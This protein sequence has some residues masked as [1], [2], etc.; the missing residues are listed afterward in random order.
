MEAK[1]LGQRRKGLSL[2]GREVFSGFMFISPW[3][4]GILLFFFLNLGQSILF[5]FNDIIIDPDVGGFNLRGA[6]LSHY[7]HILFV[8]GSFNRELADS[9]VEMVASVPLIIF[10]SLFMAILLNRAFFG[11]GLVRAI[12]F[13]PVIMATSAIE[14]SLELIMSLMMGGVSSVPPEVMQAESGFDATSIV[15]MLSEFGIPMAIVEYIVDAIAML[16]DVIR[17]SGVQILI[18]LAALQAIPPSMYEVAQIE[19]ATGYESFWKITIPMV[20]PLILT[21]MVYTIVDTFARSEVI[22]S[23]RNMMF[24][25]VTLADGTSAMAFGQSS[26][27]ALV[28][29]IAAC[30]VLLVVGW[31]MSKFVFYYN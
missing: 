8:D 2:R 7:Y 20:S 28:S 13:L 26:A 29:S 16:H 6:G 12:F 15:F 9:I 22:E 11:R 21:N 27:M 24:T 25:T 18:F 23:T 5:S 19:G 17:A 3:I 10:F 4:I 31:I 30:V 14:G 1:T